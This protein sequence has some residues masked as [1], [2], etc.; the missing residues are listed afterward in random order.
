MDDID[1]LNNK[2][3]Y[4]ADTKEI[5]ANIHFRTTCDKTSM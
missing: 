2:D 3:R 5:N 1:K 4:T